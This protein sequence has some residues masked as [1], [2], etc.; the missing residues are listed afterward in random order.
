VLQQG[1]RAGRAVDSIALDMQKA[2]ETAAGGQRFKI[3]SEHIDDWVTELH[4]SAL[5]L[6]HDPA[7]RRQW[8]DAIEQAQEIIDGLK[9]TGSRTAAEQVLKEMKRAV[10][11]GKEELLDKAV[12]WWTYDKQ[13]YNLKRISRTEMGQAMH[14]GVINGTLHDETIIGYQWRL[15]ASHPITDIC[16]YYANVEMGLGR[17]VFT[18]DAVPRHKAHPHCMCL[19]IPRVSPISRPGSKNY[20]DWLRGLSVNK[21]KQVMPDWARQVVEQ[22]TQVDALIRPDGLGLIT[23]DQHKARF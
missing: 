17:G 7:A 2:I 11:K 12:K 16:D 19:I 22:G 13:L 8:N 6:I 20:A 9:T 1:I 5:T 3:V 15:S 23:Q 10:E 18:K 14:S 21:Q 4:E